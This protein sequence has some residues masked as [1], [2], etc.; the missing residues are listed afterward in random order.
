MELLEGEN[1]PE[2]TFA[3]GFYAAEN[4]NP[5]NNDHVNPNNDTAFYSKYSELIY[6]LVLQYEISP[7]SKFYL[8]YTRYWFIN[9]KSFESFFDFLD[10]SEHEEPWVEKSFDQGVSIKYTYQFNL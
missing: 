9:G 6:N 8:V 10:Y 5:I 3:A 1:Y 7:K 4:Q 2:E